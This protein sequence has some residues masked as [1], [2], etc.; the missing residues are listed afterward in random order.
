M[1]GVIPVQGPRFSYRRVFSDLASKH[2]KCTA[3]AM[4]LTSC[5]LA[6]V[7][8]HLCLACCASR[9]QATTL[10]VHQSDV[11]SSQNWLHARFC[12]GLH[13]QCHGQIMHQS[14]CRQFHLFPPA[15]AATPSGPLAVLRVCPSLWYLRSCQG[16]C[17]WQHL[18][19]AFT[20]ACV[21]HVRGCRW[22]AACKPGGAGLCAAP[23]CMAR[24]NGCGKRGRC[25]R[26]P[27]W[28]QLSSLC[29][30]KM[31]RGCVARSPAASGPV[32]VRMRPAAACPH[33]LGSYPAATW[34]CLATAPFAAHACPGPIINSLKAS[35]SPRLLSSALGP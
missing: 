4:L 18:P 1:H 34:L 35:C 16:H 10:V 8:C 15:T 7:A 27:R 6:C 17:C 32:P 24:G 28:A 33:M 31:G 12:W 3:Q 22:P 23:R 2:K 30:C 21:Q 20:L 13:T 9:M 5:S 14:S 26:S 29:I 19:R 25:G 11:S